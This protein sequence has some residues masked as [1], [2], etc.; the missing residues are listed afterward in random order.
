MTILDQTRFVRRMAAMVLGLALL[1]PA[2][3]RL[4]AA[5][6]Q[7][8]SADDLAAR[9]QKRYESIHDFTADFEQTF[10][11]LLVKHPTTERGKVLL[12]K[13]SRVRFTYEKPERKE[14]VS[15]GVLFRSYYPENRTGTETP[16]PKG[17]EVS[18]A[19][20]FLAGR[21]NLTRDFTAKM[22]AGAPAGEL[23]LGLVPKSKQADFET[24]TLFVDAQ[25]LALLGFRT[26]DQQG[27][28]TIRFTNLKE[29]TG[30]SDRA[31]D[32]EFPKGTAI[33]R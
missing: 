28:N 27:T 14:F 19:L 21:G 3:P 7:A 23:H 18:T 8:S 26:T 32:F 11:G 17:D 16:L 9:L 10:Q 15:D 4:R 33:S 2:G 22:A 24:L 30:L 6:P 1:T 29:N 31:F 25:S 12:K 5:P 13:P 20:L